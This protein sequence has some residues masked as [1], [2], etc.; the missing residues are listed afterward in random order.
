[1]NSPSFAPDGRPFARSLRIAARSRDAVDVRQGQEKGR[2]AR[3]PAR[4]VPYRL[5]HQEPAAGRLPR[6]RQVQVGRAGARLRRGTIANCSGATRGTTAETSLAPSSARRRRPAPSSSRAVVDPCRRR[7]A[8][9]LS[10]VAARGAKRPR[11]GTRRSLPSLAPPPHARASLPVAPPL[12]RR[13]RSER[14]V[15]AV[16]TPSPLCALPPCHNNN[17]I[18][19]NNDQNDHSFRSSMASG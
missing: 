3:R 5:P 17:N 12:P 7:L 6:D 2:V 11:H 1:M 19:D 10:G 14:G 15:A 8:L 16:T 18:N 4:A 9:S 13:P